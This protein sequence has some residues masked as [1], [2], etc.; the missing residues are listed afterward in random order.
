[1]YESSICTVCLGTVTAI[2]CSGESLAAIVAVLTDLITYFLLLQ[3]A[4]DISKHACFIKLFNLCTY[5]VL[6]LCIL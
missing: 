1:M 2:R 3:F 5:P 6:V 4:F